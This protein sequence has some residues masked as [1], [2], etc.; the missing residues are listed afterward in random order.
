MPA[1]SGMVPASRDATAV[2]L[3]GLTL[4][5]AER[6]AA[7]LAHGDASRPGWDGRATLAGWLGTHLF[8][9]RRVQPLADPRLEALRRFA[10]LLRR[11]DARADAAAAGLRQLGFSPFA[12]REAIDLALA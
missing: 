9:L 10:C 4:S 3:P 5:T 11:G 12:L 1:A 2:H 8:G 6:R 7:L